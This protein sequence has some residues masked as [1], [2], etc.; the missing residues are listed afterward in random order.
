MLMAVA[1]YKITGNTH[2]R[3]IGLHAANLLAGRFSRAWNCWD[4]EPHTGWAIID[5]MMNLSLLY[6]AYE[7]DHDP[8]YLHIAKYKKMR[9]H[10]EKLL[11][12]LS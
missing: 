6:S 2:S 10:V 8:R 11:P 12:F 4:R 5:C 7:E 3:E 1:D 9:C